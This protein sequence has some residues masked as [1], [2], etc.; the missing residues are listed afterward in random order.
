MRA[1]V[2]S[3]LMLLVAA[4]A[5]AKKQPQALTPVH[6]GVGGQAVIYNLPL[7]V[8]LEQGYFRDEGL[9]VKVIDFTGGGKAAQA[10]VADA[11]QVVSGAYEHT[12][13]LQARGQAL[14][15]F[16][17]AS[18]TPSSPWASPPKLCR[19]IG[20]SQT[21]EARPSASVR[22]APQPRCSPTACWHREG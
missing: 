12:L 2:F 11:V 3:C 6:L 1:F 8:A 19:I 15:A 16:V 4:S 20:R 10:L 13:R 22:P 14:Q 5:T 9:D 21:C 7:T 18:E 17:L